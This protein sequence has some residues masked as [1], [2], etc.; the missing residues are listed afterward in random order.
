MRPILTE[1]GLDSV[2]LNRIK[3]ACDTCRERRAQ[4][5]PGHTV[6]PSTALPGKFNEEAECDLM[7]SQQEH[8]LF[9]H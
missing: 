9:H 7:I 3:G 8:D 4:D 5:K 2:G 1:D 6:M